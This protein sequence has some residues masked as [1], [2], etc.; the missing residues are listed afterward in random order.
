MMNDPHSIT[1]MGQAP[2]GD[3][4]YLSMDLISP[5]CCDQRLDV[6]HAALDALYASFLAQ[7]P[8]QASDD[9]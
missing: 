9:E 7:H 4:F 2:N 8:K 5:A 1:V 6:M 3:S